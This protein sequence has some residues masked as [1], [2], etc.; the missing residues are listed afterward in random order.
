MNIILL[1]EHYS[2]LLSIFDPMS[3]DLLESALHRYAQLHAKPH[4]R[5]LNRYPITREMLYIPIPQLRAFPFDHTLRLDEKMELFH[6]TSVN[7]CQTWLLFGYEKVP[8]EK[9]LPYRD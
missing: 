7:D 5:Q 3:L 6:Q 4:H 2:L 9:L 1:L 8:P